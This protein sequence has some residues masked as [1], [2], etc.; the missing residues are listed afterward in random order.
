[1][2]HIEIKELGLTK[3]VTVSENEYGGLSKH[4]IPFNLS[5]TG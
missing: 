3:S 1:M 4:G 5:E 2:M